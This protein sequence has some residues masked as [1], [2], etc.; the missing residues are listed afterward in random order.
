MAMHVFLKGTISGDGID[1]NV[2]QQC[3]N[4][5]QIENK[6]NKSRRHDSYLLCQIKYIYI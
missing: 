5:F 2:K 4:R 3:V 1:G 6:A